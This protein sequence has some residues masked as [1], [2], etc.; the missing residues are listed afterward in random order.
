MGYRQIRHQC[1]H[2]KLGG[3][4]QAQAQAQGREGGIEDPPPTHRPK[5]R[6]VFD[7]LNPGRKGRR[8]TER[9]WKEKEK[10]PPVPCYSISPAT[11]NQSMNYKIDGKEGKTTSQFVTSSLVPI[12]KLSK[13]S[14]SL[15]PGKANHGIQQKYISYE[16]SAT[17][18]HRAL[19]SDR[20]G[21]ATTC[22]DPDPSPGAP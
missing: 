17:P 7:R 11:P 15:S 6:G 1:L 5:K 20:G 22:S 2:M 4:L 12:K 14:N 3:T 10:T 9:K 19:A 13:I 18:R 21:T 8:K 16:W